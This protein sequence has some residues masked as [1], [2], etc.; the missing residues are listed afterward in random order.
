MR[1]FTIVVLVLSSAGCSGP[2]LIRTPTLYL[3]TEN[4]PFAAVPAALQSNQVDVLYV[5][6][7]QPKYDEAAGTVAYDHRRSYSMAFGSAIV[8]FGDDEVS[9]GQ[10]V[11]ASRTEHRDVDLG[12]QLKRVTELGRFPQTP[13][14]LVEATRQDQATL[15][16]GSVPDPA[17]LAEVARVGEAMR[18]ELRRRLALTPRK[19]VYVFIHG[20][21]NDFEHAVSVI[22]EIWHFLPRIGVPIAYTWPAGLGGLRGYFYD[23]ESGEFTIY[24]LK[25][26]LRLLQNCD[27]VEKVHLIA[28]SRGTDVL[29]T[30]LRELALEF[31]LTSRLPQRRSK[32]GNVIVAAPDLDLDVIQQRVAAEEFHRRIDRLTLYMSKTDTAI[33]LS[34]WLFVSQKRVGRVQMADL[35][36]ETLQRMSVSSAAVLIDANVD[37]GFIGHSY[38]YSHPAVISDLILMLRDDRDPGAEHGRPLGR[39]EGSF[40]WRI[41]ED[42]PNNASAN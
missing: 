6:D 1:H 26:F 37:A 24:H 27:E 15:G 12:L 19:E 9:W 31:P 28:H 10:L 35:T 21:N 13:Y 7:R 5:T 32:L 36:P 11:Q 3:G 4:N 39:A 29:M 38:F 34:T 23:R 8:Q 20:F 33:G 14:P 40:I 41:D 42:Y 18:G 25:Q 17:V 2:E 16:D 30:A 22:S